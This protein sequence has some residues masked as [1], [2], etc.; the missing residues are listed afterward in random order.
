M[1][2]ERTDG[3]HALRSVNREQEF[4]QREELTISIGLILPEPTADIAPKS[5]TM[6]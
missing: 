3:E 6:K 2:D 4:R 5:E 1:T